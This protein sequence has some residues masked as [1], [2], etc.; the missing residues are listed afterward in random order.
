[1]TRKIKDLAVK[2]GS[3][4]VNGENKNRYKNIGSILEMDDGGKMMLLDRTFNP[5]GVPYKEGSDQIAV[6][7]FDPKP[8]EAEE[9]PQPSA[10]RPPIDDDIPF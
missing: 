9:A 6:S 10:K 7:L 3:Y 4:M 2:T 5:A 1:M 8:R